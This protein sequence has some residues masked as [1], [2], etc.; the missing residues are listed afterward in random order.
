MPLVVK[1][2]VEPEKVEIC[3]T[4]ET[5]VTNVGAFLFKVSFCPSCPVSLNQKTIGIDS[6]RV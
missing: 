4:F 2:S 1:R 3:D 5:K 6:K